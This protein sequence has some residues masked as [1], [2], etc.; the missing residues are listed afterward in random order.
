MNE[1]QNRFPESRGRQR[2]PRP[3]APS[4]HG[5]AESI[6]LAESEKQELEKKR[7]EH[8]RDQSSRK[9]LAWGM[10][11]L[12]T[13]IFII[14]AVF[15]LG[16]HHLFPEKWHW[17]GKNELQDIKKLRS[18]RRCRRSGNELCTAISRRALIADRGMENSGT[19]A[20][21]QNLGLS[22]A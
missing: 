6:S 18:E 22:K 9:I 19:D 12:M 11:I 1:N 4:S 21:L 5:E 15:T 8:Y 7:S 2:V 3:S 13:V 10:W 14:G 20:M 17:L 16:Y